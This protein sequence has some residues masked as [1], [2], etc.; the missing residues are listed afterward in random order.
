VDSG[1]LVNEQIEAGA[2]FLGEFQRYA[3]I[4][5]AFW[6]KDSDEGNWNLY[7]ASDRITDKNFDRAYGEV[8]RI[9]EQLQ[10]P[11]LNPFQVKVL[12][13]D[14]RLAK[15][16]LDVLQRFPKKAPIRLRG[17]L[18]GGISTDETYLYSPLECFRMVRDEQDSRKVRRVPVERLPEWALGREP[19]RSA[20]PNPGESLAALL[21]RAVNWERPG[22][23]GVWQVIGDLVEFWET[24]EKE[25]PA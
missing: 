13:A 19:D 4:R 14:H 9:T 10:D 7:V 2:R 17:A 16:A 22:F 3:P 24:P 5:A 11:W 23:T 12:G 15:A 21:T 1:P 8:G 20:R 25:R 18:L 6:L